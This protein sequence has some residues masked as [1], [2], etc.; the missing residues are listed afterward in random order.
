MGI[1]RQVISQ[2]YSPICPEEWELDTYGKFSP[3][4]FSCHSY[5]LSCSRHCNCTESIAQTDGTW[6]AVLDIANTFFPIPF[7]PKS[8]SPDQFTLMAKPPICVCSI[9]QEVRLMKGH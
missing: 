6:Y 9:S 8:K 7:S 4:E 2:Y 1:V 3:T 5:S